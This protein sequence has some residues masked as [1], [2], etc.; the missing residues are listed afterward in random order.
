MLCRVMLTTLRSLLMHQQAFVQKLIALEEQAVYK[1]VAM[2]CICTL[3]EAVPHFN[4]RDNL[5]VAV[6][7]G[8]STQ[9]DVVRSVIFLF[10][11]ILVYVNFHCI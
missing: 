8:I 9:D 2:R 1:R 6:V 5:L 4:F 10:F 3:L 7:K 11:K